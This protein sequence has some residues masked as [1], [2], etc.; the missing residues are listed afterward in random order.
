EQAENAEDDDNLNQRH[1]TPSHNNLAQIRNP[2]IEIRNKNKTNSKSQILMSQT[3]HTGV[4]NFE[5]RVCFGFRYSDFGFFAAANVSGSVVP[6]GSEHF[7]AVGR[8]SVMPGDRADGAADGADGA[9][10]EGDL[11]AAGVEGL[12]PC[13][14]AVAVARRD[15]ELPVA[16]VR[17]HR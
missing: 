12:R 2:N 15:L 1:A 3:S 6:V 10:A 8:H 4:S 16:V 5:L 13:G 7:A 9:V 14:I 11:D 17:H